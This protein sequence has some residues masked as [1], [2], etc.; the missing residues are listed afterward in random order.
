MRFSQHLALK[1]AWAMPVG[2]GYRE[3]R[4]GYALDPL[5]YCA[6]ARLTISFLEGSHY[7][8]SGA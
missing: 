6:Q 2:A 7:L 3:T 8:M 4:I 5:A 1:A